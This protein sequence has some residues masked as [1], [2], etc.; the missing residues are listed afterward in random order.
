MHWEHLL[1]LAR[2]S[3]YSM[4]FMQFICLITISIYFIRPKVTK[5]LIY[6]AIISLA[7]LIQALI[8]ELNLLIDLKEIKDKNIE[9]KAMYIYLAVETLCCGLYIREN[10][11]SS[12][13]KKLIMRS[14]VL[15]SIYIIG[16]G[17][18]NFTTKFLPAHIEVIEGLIIIAYCLYFFYELFTVKPDKIL[19]REPSFWAISGMLI[20]FSAIT[21]LFLFFNYLRD[22]HSP[23]ARS[24]Y[25]I[26]N[27][28]YSLLFM[29]FI[30]AIICDKKILKT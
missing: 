6:L 9:Q 25:A 27:I 17:L 7:S 23:L 16:F 22:S 2:D 29:M 12:P 28:S 5:S 13:G 19:Y 15:F 20:L 11:R 26:N 14:A 18:L 30:I 3:Y 10:I 21:P 24:L 4:F 8:E 1:R